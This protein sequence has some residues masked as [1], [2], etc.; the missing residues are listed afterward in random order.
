MFYLVFEGENARHAQFCSSLVA[1]IIQSNRMTRKGKQNNMTEGCSTGHIFSRQHV[2]LFFFYACGGWG[3]GHFAPGPVSCQ[4]VGL[5]L[6]G[7]SWQL[8][9]TCGNLCQH[10]ATFDNL[11]Q[12]LATF[13]NMWQRLATF[14][15][16]CQF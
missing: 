6:H 10:I 4:G 9:A 12:C 2:V 3:S 15:Y 13:G 11:W 7:S 5:I 16:F 1:S 8:L 14:G